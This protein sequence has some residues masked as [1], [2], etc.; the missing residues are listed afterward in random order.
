MTDVI[1]QTVKATGI[2]VYRVLRAEDRLQM[3]D[4]NCAGHLGGWRFYPRYQ[5]SPSRRGWDSE[6]EA[7]KS[8]KLTI[9]GYEDAEEPKPKR[10]PRV[11]SKI[12]R[13]LQEAR[14]SAT[15]ETA[16]FGFGSEQWLRVQARHGE[17]HHTASGP[18]NITDLIVD[19]TKLYRETWIVAALDRVIE[20]AEG[21]DF[22]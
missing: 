6:A 1:L 17:E 18:V 2:L 12:L 20:W 9:V 8:Y 21:G 16:Q 10:T 14:K 5:R 19:R 7:L 3:G 13:E 15:F 11:P 4:L 22:E